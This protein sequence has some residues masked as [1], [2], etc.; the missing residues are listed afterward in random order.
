MQKFGDKFQNLSEISGFQNL[1]I[2]I[3]PQLE[4]DMQKLGTWQPSS[5]I[6]LEKN[7]DIF[8]RSKL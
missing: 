7:P 6:F 8:Q 4:A 3:L 5:R 1:V 2:E